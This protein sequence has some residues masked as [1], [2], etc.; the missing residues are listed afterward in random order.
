MQVIRT[1]TDGNIKANPSNL[2][3]FFQTGYFRRR[4]VGLDQDFVGLLA[5]R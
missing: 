2:T 1:G 5:E 3:G 4:G